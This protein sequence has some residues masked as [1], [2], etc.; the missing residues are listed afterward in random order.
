MD[1]GNNP[2]PPAGGSKARHLLC[3][4]LGACHPHHDHVELT[5]M[6][7][8]WICNSM[9]LDAAC[10]SEGKKQLL[11]PMIV[12]NRSEGACLIRER[13][14]LLPRSRIRITMDY[15]KRAALES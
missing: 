15:C 9:I 14:P 6:L 5:P 11:M 2:P 10:E 3:W 4:E 12:P 1:I 13:R 8:S 7:L